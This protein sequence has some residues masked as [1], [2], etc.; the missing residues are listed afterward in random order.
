[1]N[2]PSHLN[3]KPWLA[4]W[5]SASAAALCLSGLPAFAQDNTLAIKTLTEQARFWESKGRSDLAAAAWKRLLQLDPKNSDALAGMAQH[6]I[7]SNRPEAARQIAEELK[8]QPQANKEAIRRIEGAVT[9]KSLNTKLLDQARAAARAGR[10]DEAV[11][12][13][14]QLL[15]GRS[16]NGPI[17]LEYFQTLGGT[18]SGWEEARRGLERLSAEDPSN[19]VVALAYAQH[20]TYRAATRREGIRLLSELARKPSVGVAATDAWRKGLIWLEAGRTDAGLYQ[21]YLNVQPGDAAIRARLAGLNQATA[22][23]PLDARSLALRDAYSALNIGDIGEAEKRFSTLLSS[24]PRNPDALGGLGVVRLKQERFAEAEKLL[25]DAIRLS[26]NRKWEE[27]LGTARFWR[28]LDEGDQAAAGGDIAQARRLY[29]RAAQLDPKAE[30]PPAA[31]ADLLVQEGRLNDAEK[32]YRA[33]RSQHPKSV[34]VLRGFAGVLVRQGKVEEALALAE[35]LSEADKEELGYGSLRAEQYRLKAMADIARGDPVAAMQAFEEALLWDPNSPWLRLELARLYHRSGATSE[36]FGL[37]D[38]LLQSRPDMPDALH[39]AAL[40][41]AEAKE[42]TLALNMLEKIPTSARTREMAELQRKMWVRAQVGKAE[43]LARMGQKAPA[44]STLDQALKA[45]GR[46]A[47]L[48]AAIAQVMVNLGDEARSIGMMR[49]LLA[50]TPKPDLDLLVQYAGLLLRTRQDVELAAQLRQLYAQN[51]SPSQRKDVDDIRWAYSVRQ[52]DAQREAGNYAA[53]YEIAAQLLSERPNDI[54]AQQALARLYNSA[55]EPARALAWYHQVLQ[56]M[57]EPDVPTLVA[58]GG[59]ALAAGDL[60]YAQSALDA[61]GRMAPSNPDVLS[62]QGRL[63]RAQGK[64]KL[65]VELL[66]QAQQVSLAQSQMAKVGPLGVNMVDYTLPTPPVRSGAAAGQAMPLIPNPLGGRSVVNSPMPAA[67]PVMQPPVVPTGQ[68]SSAAPVSP[69]YP[70]TY[71]QQMSFNGVSDGVGP[72]DSVYGADHDVSRNAMRPVQ[73]QPQRSVPTSVYAEEP[74]QAPAASIPWQQPAAPA[75][76]FAPPTAVMSAPVLTP[77]AA[78]PSSAF[79]AGADAYRSAP[80][81]YQQ[82]LQA[83]PSFTAQAAPQPVVEASRPMPAAS[84]ET[85]IPVVP[86]RRAAG[87]GSLQREIDEL[88]A[89]RAGSISAGGMWRGR[90]GDSGTSELTDFSTVVE[91][92]YPLGQG[93]HLVLR[94][95]PVFLSA[96]RINATD[97]NASQR[98]GANALAIVGGGTGTTREQQDSGLAL[99][100]GYETAHLKLDLGTTPLGFQVANVVG[101]VAYNDSFGDVKL[102]LDLSRRPV[103]D[104]LLSYAGTVDDVTGRTWGGVTATGGR[105]EVGVEQGRFGIFGYGGLHVLQGKNVVNNSRFEVG[106]GAY[107]K[108]IQDTDM[109]FTAGVAV[110]ALGYKRNLR[111]FTLGH[112]GYFSPQ[113]YFSLALPLELTGRYG[114][115]AYKVDGSIGIQ[116][117]R[118][119]SAAYFPGD[120]TLQSNWET[121]A[122]ANS[123]AAPVGVSYNSFYPS[124]SKTGLGFRLGGEAEY[125]FAPQWAVGGKVSIDNASDYTQT[126]GMVYLRYSFDP[127]YTQ[128]KMPPK[129]LKVGQ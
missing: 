111:Y 88:R 43:V 71:P 115:V 26:G 126:A 60:Q 70:S 53:A 83:P 104:S 96:G 106:G 74:I 120:A 8:R 63:A 35:S 19:A 107:Y 125:Q 58:A 101:G 42:Y 128:A 55:G 97:L 6:E 65:A 12:L 54:P 7:D 118:E 75:S 127:I 81:P 23:R 29:E 10:Q 59:A 52:A 123:V 121:V 28:A 45:A 57:D 116:S 72:A 16:L 108:V 61:A 41:S 49:T 69:R 33:V 109:E 24:G 92:R 113:R 87:P 31:L 85:P 124:Q 11:G 5:A 129:V 47:D 44:M 99:S 32:A 51:L 62:T 73:Y 102:K 84:W 93:G 3:R 56:L 122:A 39:A 89:D 90:S 114:K 98:F 30:R 13:Y 105:M 21:S 36:A 77:V 27:A 68:P 91:G 34:D 78:T 18:S 100:I 119:N 37:M 14:R 1:M 117:F 40:M 95:E 79:N 76:V 82:P 66:Q 67:R 112:G 25:L 38:G 9:Q 48:L 46:D 15:E 80:A 64:N 86:A 4:M 110:T 103:T 20:L 94:M 2:H 22:P 17:A 50:Q